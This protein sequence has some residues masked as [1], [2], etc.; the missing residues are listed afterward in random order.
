MLTT[1]ATKDY[2]ALV[3]EF[4]LQAIESTEEHRRAIEM[5]TKL[6]MSERLN[7]GERVYYKALT[8][9]IRHYEAEFDTFEAFSPRAYLAALLEEHAMSQKDIERA[10]G[11]PQSV[12]SAVLNGKRGFTESQACKLAAHFKVRPSAFYAIEQPRQKAARG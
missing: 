11:I 3:R 12:I 6:S 2:F 9:L 10:C 4:P 1:A 8:A 5:L 7:A